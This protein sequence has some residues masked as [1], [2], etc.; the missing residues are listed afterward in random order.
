MMAF[1]ATRPWTERSRRTIDAV[2]VIK[3]RKSAHEIACRHAERQLVEFSAC[4]MPSTAS[5]GVFQRPAEHPVLA[6][7][8]CALHPNPPILS[9][10]LMPRSRF[11]DWVDCMFSV[12]KDERY[13][14]R[15]EATAAFGEAV[16]F[17]KLLVRL[18]LA[19]KFEHVEVIYFSSWNCCGLC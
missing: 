2:P 16:I 19:R 8:T 18:A 13:R 11:S 6:P 5:E 4:S 17:K 7:A 9:S 12:Q 14:Q 1:R 3:R 15:V 10:P